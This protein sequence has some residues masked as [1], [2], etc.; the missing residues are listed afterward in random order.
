MVA[1]EEKGAV[2]GVVVVEEKG[3]VEGK[4]AVGSRRG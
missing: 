2:E 3:A 1:V 4:G